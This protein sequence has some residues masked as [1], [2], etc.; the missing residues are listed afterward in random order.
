[1]GLRR[2][3]AV[4]LLIRIF[5]LQW[6]VRAVLLLRR[7]QLD[8]N[9][10]LVGIDIDLLPVRLIIFCN[11]LQFDGSLRHRWKLRVSMLIGMHFPMHRPAFAKFLNL[12]LAAEIENHSCVHNRLIMLICHC[13]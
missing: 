7:V 9:G 12:V 4:T 6:W 3:N 11:H 2:P 10:L 5:R 8:V 13:N 1:M